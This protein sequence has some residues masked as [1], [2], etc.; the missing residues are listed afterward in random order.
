MPIKTASKSKF[1]D[2]NS[3]IIKNQAP[4][5]KV[6]PLFLQ[7]LAVNEPRKKRFQTQR[8]LWKEII[9]RILPSVYLN[10]SP[11]H[12]STIWKINQLLLTVYINIII[13]YYKVCKINKKW[14]LRWTLSSCIYNKSGRCPQVTEMCTKIHF[15]VKKLPTRLSAIHG[16]DPR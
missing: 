12:K 2:L 7:N 13:L 15:S 3:K 16:R 8:H 6:D 5:Y 9:M 4:E 11:P 10:K 14:P 1:S